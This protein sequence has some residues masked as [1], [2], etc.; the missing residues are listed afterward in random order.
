MYFL[1]AIEYKKNYYEAYNN[2]GVIYTFLKKNKKAELNLLKSAEI[3]PRYAIVKNLGILY[4]TRLK[5]PQKAIE[6]YKKFLK[7][8]PNASERNAVKAWIQILNI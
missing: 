4:D 6:N 7:I 1:L 8:S 2:L 3:N 5:N